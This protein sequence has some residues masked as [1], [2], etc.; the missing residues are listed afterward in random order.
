LGGYNS[1]TEASAFEVTLIPLR[2]VSIA[3][4]SKLEGG[5]LFV[6]G[7]RGDQT[8]CLRAI[9]DRDPNRIPVILFS[10]TGVPTIA[11]FERGAPCIDLGK[12]ATIQVPELLGSVTSN[13]RAEMPGSLAIERTSIGVIV[14]DEKTYI[15]VDVADGRIRTISKHPGLWFV[16]KWELGFDDNAGKF[17]SLYHQPLSATAA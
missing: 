13:D 16:T 11:R 9:E 14:A 2:G 1:V 15:M 10:E 6:M 3:D 5:H 7:I 8:L 4:F 12:R 17:H